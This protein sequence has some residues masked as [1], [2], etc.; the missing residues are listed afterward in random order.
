MI[1]SLSLKSRKIRKFHTLGL[2]KVSYLNNLIIN[3]T[4]SNKASC[5][6]KSA[7]DLSILNA[8]YNFEINILLTFHI[9]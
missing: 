4:F 5:Q 1:T 6:L 8:S 9:K 7:S 2:K 3:Y